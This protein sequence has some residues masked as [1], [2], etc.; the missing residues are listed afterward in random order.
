LQ[1]LAI[2][3]KNLRRYSISWLQAISPKILNREISLNQTAV[4]A[5]HPAVAYT[6]ERVPTR[7]DIRRHCR[8][9]T[10]TI[11]MCVV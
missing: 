11:N 9:R 4:S 2:D 10:S 5:L 7:V 6:E 1:K 8:A 3:N